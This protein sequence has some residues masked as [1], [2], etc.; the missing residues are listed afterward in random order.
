MP[1]RGMI[2][3]VRRYAIHD[4]PGIRTAVFFKGCPLACE[5]CHNPEG[6]ASEE[7]LVVRE[8]RCIGCRACLE[9]CAHGAISWNGTG[10]VT[11]RERCVACGACAEACFAEARGIAGK[12]MT[13]EETMAEIERDIPFYEESG[14]GVTFSGGEPLAQPEYLGALLRAC[15]ARGIHTALDTCGYAPWETIDSIRRNVDLFLYDIKVINGAKHRALTGVSNELILSNLR[16]LAELG[17]GILVRVPVIPGVNDDDESIREIGAFAESLPRV[18][19]IDILPYN[20]LGVDKYARLGKDC[21]PQ[22]AEPLT[23][24]RMAS[25]VRTLSTFGLSVSTGG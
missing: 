4:G 18:M 5:W 10:P 6:Q 15:K 8:R 17:H 21:A 20:R 9:V 23:G 19:G 3:D 13:V 22:R 2:F 16:A 25:I 24:E 14:G 1:I 11:A 12:V 7:E